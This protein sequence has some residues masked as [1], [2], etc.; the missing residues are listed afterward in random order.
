MNIQLLEVR[1][2][3]DEDHPEQYYQRM[4]P[5]LRVLLIVQHWHRTPLRRCDLS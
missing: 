3:R 4:F 1:S 2:R 5:Y